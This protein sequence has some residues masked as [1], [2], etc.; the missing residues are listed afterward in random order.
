MSYAA[1]FLLVAAL[2]VIGY[3]LGKYRALALVGGGGDVVREPDG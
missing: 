1:L 3:W 2:A